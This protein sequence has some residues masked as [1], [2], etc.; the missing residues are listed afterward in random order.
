M[1][2]SR[3]QLTASVD[4]APIPITDV[5][6]PGTLIHTSE[7]DPLIIDEPQLTASNVTAAD[8]TLTLAWGGS[9]TGN[10]LLKDVV[11]PAN[12]SE[13]PITNGHLLANGLDA[14]AWTDT[15]SAINVAGGVIRVQ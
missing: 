4:G 15:P 2:Y 5:A 3:H 14:R 1:A 10:L 12:S 6:G 9:A 13:I 11:I 7:A 8:A